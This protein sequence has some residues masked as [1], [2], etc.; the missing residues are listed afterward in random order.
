MSIKP[1]E[2]INSSKGTYQI[3]QSGYLT[4]IFN[5]SL[6]VSRNNKLFRPSP[7]INK[8]GFSINNIKSETKYLNLLESEEKNNKLEKIQNNINCKFNENDEQNLSNCNINFQIKFLELQNNFFELGDFSTIPDFEKHLY[9]EKKHFQLKGQYFFLHPLKTRLFSQKK[10]ME[11]DNICSNRKI[12]LKKRYRSKSCKSYSLK[13]NTK[14]KRKFFNNGY[15]KLLNCEIDELFINFKIRDN[16]LINFDIKEITIKNIENNTKID[17]KYPSIGL[18]D[19]EI[20]LN[21]LCKNI[22]INKDGESNISF[23]DEYVEYKNFPIK[24]GEIFYIEKKPKNILDCEYSLNNKKNNKKI[25][26]AVK[27]RN[28]N[29]KKFG[30]LNQFEIN[31]NSLENFPFFPSLNIERII[32]V[33]DILKSI[34]ENGIIG[35][36]EKPKL[37]KDERNAKY[38]INKR[39][40]IIYQNKEGNAQYILYLNEFHILYLILFYYYQI[41]EELLEL[42]KNF[43][44]NKKK[45]EISNAKNKVEMLINKCNIIVKNITK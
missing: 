43:R 6:P 36:K 4:N 30:Y 38:M 33:K 1:Y 37:I 17:K 21:N 41:K 29:E 10:N 45:E 9:N 35:F 13:R 39:F 44:G 40:E 23:D 19:T 3:N 31:N 11:S 8:N 27:I 12:L 16:F 2:Q 22:I 14:R 42:N 26:N 15:F 7:L 32:Y 20:F 18:K 28:R 34:I 5:K 24:V 25:K